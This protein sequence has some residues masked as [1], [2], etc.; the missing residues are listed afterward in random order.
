[1]QKGFPM[2]TFFVLL[3]ALTVLALPIVSSNATA[4][5]AGLAAYWPF[6]ETSD[7][8]LVDLSDRG[9]VGYIHSALRVPGVSGGALNFNGTTDYARVKNS[10]SLNCSSQ[11]TI[12]CWV[13]LRQIDPV[14]GWGQTVIRKEK[15]Y[16]LGIGSGGKVGFQICV[17][18]GWV[19]GWA[20]SQGS[21]QPFRWYHLAGVWNGQ[22][23]KM[24]INGVED[25]NTYPANGPV[26]SGDYDVYIGEFF[27]SDYEK[28]NGSVDE[29][30]IYN[31]GL[32]PDSILAHYN[33]LRPALPLA[34]P[35]SPNPTYNQKPLLRWHSSKSISTYRLQ[36]ATD[37]SFANP[38]VSLP[39]TDTFFLPAVN[40][41]YGPIFWRVGNEKDT[42]IWS[43]ISS[44]TIQDPNI[45]LLIPYGP[46][47]TRERKP[48]LKWHSVKGA[49]SYMIQIF[50]SPNVSSPFIADAV[51]D[52]TYSP[53]VKLP[54][55]TISW[56]I[57]SNL[58]S[59]YSVPDTFRI[60]SDSVPLLVPMA[61]DSQYNCNPKFVWH[62]AEGA[63]FYRLFIDTTGYF[64]SP[65]ISVPLSDTT[66]T[67]L[68]GLPYGRMVWRV[69]AS[70]TVE[71]YSDP[72]TFWVMKKSA[73]NPV[74]SRSGPGLNSASFSTI[75]H[76]ILFSYSLEKPSAIALKVFTLA[77][78][79]ITALYEGNASAGK[80]SLR[81]DGKDKQRTSVPDGSYLAVCR[82]NGRVFA[83]RIALVR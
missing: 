30:K 4:A 77:G 69:S 6:D 20:L 62:P 67:P 82:I 19:G 9:N 45:P 59:S 74:V 61:P 11:I 65:L 12:E 18:G 37:Q 22:T 70:S 44:V 1:M 38:I 8:L 29:L 78:S 26:Y 32:P 55:G 7:T 49:A 27:E 83:K 14:S 15:A 60:L 51:V 54:I 3:G 72:D 71:R 31:Y 73:V 58:S 16:A 79:E 2:R 80:H 17:Q 36:I 40:L 63:S 81:W 56:A 25:P 5:D 43:A 46:D 66:F 34:I 76:E 68:V 13:N 33:A 10:P 53:S 35:Y 75:G 50:S 52:T 21:I 47:P 39:T 42:S 64:I 41:P 24:Y 23:M 48:L 28:L 57:K